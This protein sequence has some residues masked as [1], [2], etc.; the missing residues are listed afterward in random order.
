MSKNLNMIV[1]GPPASG[2]GTLSRK[3]AEHYNLPHIEAGALL[4]E[5]AAQHDKIGRDIHRIISAGNFVPENLIT[6]PI[7]EKL[8]SEDCEHGF[9]LDGFPRT[10]SQAQK[11]DLFL[12]SQDIQLTHVFNLTADE[13]HL[14]NRMQ[15]CAL[16]SDKKRADDNLSTFYNRLAKY[17]ELTSAV[18]P[19][20]EVQGLS[21]DVDANGSQEATWK[22]AHRA[23]VTNRLT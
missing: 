4:R 2:K 21:R 17:T 16:N 22:N 1:V 18:G 7:F 15:I 13:E 20:Y 11:L 19:Y 6:A 9:I 5:R 14:I 3:L 8:T 12:K 23:I 10:V